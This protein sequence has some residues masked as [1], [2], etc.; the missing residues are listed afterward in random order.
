MYPH[1]ESLKVVHS[2]NYGFKLSAKTF[3]SLIK[4]KDHT[5]AIG[6]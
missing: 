6:M 3:T 1:I 4:K 5:Y 2:S